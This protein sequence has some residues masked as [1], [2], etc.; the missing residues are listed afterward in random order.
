M[1]SGLSLGSFVTLSWGRHMYPKRLVL[2]PHEGDGRQLP[3]LMTHRVQVAP[4]LLGAQPSCGSAERLKEEAPWQRLLCPGL[5][6]VMGIPVTV[7]KNTQW[8]C[9]HQADW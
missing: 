1:G 8:G 6:T 3:C 5:T 7:G 2:P 4:T 9:H